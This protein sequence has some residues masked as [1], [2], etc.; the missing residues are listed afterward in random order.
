GV[1]AALAIGFLS[2]AGPAAAQQTNV[3][4]NPGFETGNATGWFGFGSPVLVVEN[5][6]VHSGNYACAVTNRTGTYMGAAQMMASVLQPGQTC[7]VSA[8]VML[9]GGTSP[10]T[11]QLTMQKTDGSGTG[12][13]EIASGS[14]T[15]SGWTQLSGTYTYNPSGT[16]TALNF[17]IEM[18]TG[19]NSYYLDDVQFNAPITV[20]NPP[21]SGVSIVDWNNVHQR[22]DGFGAS[23][24]WDGSWSTAEEQL[25]FSTNNSIAYQSASYNGIGLSLLR[26][27]I[28]PASTNFANVVPSTTETTV[29]QAAQSYGVKVWSTPWTPPPSFKSINDIYDTNTATLSG[30]NGGSFL[31]S[32]NNITNLNYAAQL[33]NYVVSMKNNFGVNIYAISVQNEPDANVTSYE[34]CQ[35]TGAQIHDFATN[36]F[37]ALAAQGAGSTKIIV[38]ESEDWSGDTALYT[39]T[40][41]DPNAAADVSI[42]ANHDYVPNNGV[43]D[44]SSPAALNVSGKALWETEVALLSGSDSSINNGVY[45]AQRIYQY[46]TQANANAYHYWWL[47]SLAAGNEGLLDNSF[48][49]TKRL[50]AFG[51]YSRFVRPNYN[52]IN[53]TSSQVSSLISAYKDSA[54]PAFAIVVVNTNVATG[55]I[56]TINLA[57]FTTASVTPWITS[58]T[59]NLAPQTPVVVANGSFTYTIPALSVVTFVGA[60]STSV[61]PTIGNV[62]D[63]TVN[64]GVTLLVTNTASAS[65]VPP[66]TLSF[67]SANSFPASATVNSSS[68]VFSW[69]P[70]VSQANTMNIIQVQVTDTGTGLSATNNFEVVVNAVTNPVV[71][72]VGLSSGLVSMTVNGPQGPDYTLLTSSNLTSWQ[73]LLKTNSPAIPFTISDT[74]LSQPDRFY[75]FQIGP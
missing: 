68:G 58:S 43:G 4:A 40:L 28:Y 16:V 5:T 70:M 59:L 22:I 34:A 53:A 60:A 48:A 39:P 26:N 15:A 74:N 42:V 32:G 50:F 51:Q 24:A 41:S 1:Q 47:R 57:N 23:S 44:Q 54:S 29:M 31:G 18:P 20:S 13:T 62:P 27:H 10:Q 14:V 75:K 37:N 67:S 21:I 45:Y 55:V 72:G 25:F 7:N 8:W 71:R 52:R 56:Q 19:T 12:Y 73:V 35:W 33:A 61:P 11:M 6:V 3:L 63:Q 36:L 30:T 46:M 17:Y 49:V 64:A 9:D 65:D 2:Q 38:P 66:N 69:R